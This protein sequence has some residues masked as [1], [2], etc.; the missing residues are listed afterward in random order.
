M[1][2]PAYADVVARL[3]AAGCV[4][5]EDEARLLLD[6]AT[7]SELTRL[8]TAREAGTPLEQLVG[9]ADFCG[10]R[11]VVEPSVFVPRR[12]TELLV[13]EAVRRAP[14]ARVAVDLCCGSG[15]IAAV[16]AGRL[17]AAEVHAA[18]L[19]PAAVRCARRNVAPARVHEGDL[20]AALPTA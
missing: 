20:F 17:P 2:A 14:G 8:V 9:W 4:F 11:I 5:A 18:D 19:D 6:A 7:G 13:R 10:R 12:R 3:R 1:D 16:L 15:A